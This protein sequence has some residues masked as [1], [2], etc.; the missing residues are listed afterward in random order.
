MSS[1][2]RASQRIDWGRNSLDVLLGKPGTIK[3]VVVPLRSV[4]SAESVLRP[5]TALARQAGARL[6]VVH[7]RAP[8]EGADDDDVVLIDD[9]RSMAVRSR[10]SQHLDALAQHWSEATGVEVTA[11]SRT[12]AR[13]AFA[14]DAEGCAESD[15]VVVGRGEQSLWN[16]IRCGSILDEVLHY[17]YSVLVWPTG[18]PRPTTN[19]DRV[20]VS[21]DE[22]L[23]AQAVARRL[24]A[25]VGRSPEYQLVR[26]IPMHFLR[27]LQRA[28]SGS[29]VTLQSPAVK[30]RTEAWMDLR[31]MQSALESS[32]ATA[33]AAVVFDDAWAGRAIVSQVYAR[34]ADLLVMARRPRLW[35]LPIPRPAWLYAAWN[36]PVPVLLCPAKK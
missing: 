24:V 29:W 14:L 34:R 16:R 12:E 15:I 5:A 17:R 30:L 11:S 1:A 35:P 27:G 25:L 26:T 6:H 36:S 22:H 20:L 21:V 23:D 10:L 2:H 3:R 13:M 9:G 32:G 4:A 33:N 19:F 28:G 7:V 31:R 8:Q 18:S